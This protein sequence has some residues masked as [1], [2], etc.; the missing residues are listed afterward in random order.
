MAHFRSIHL[1]VIT[2]VP[3]PV[4]ELV[5]VNVQFPLMM[6]L[7]VRVPLSVSVFT[8]GLPEAL[9]II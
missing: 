9:R 3:E 6:L 4:H 5:P 2:K 7:F 8:G 1:R